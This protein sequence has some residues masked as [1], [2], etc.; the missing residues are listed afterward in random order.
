MF[1]E[2]NSENLGNCQS[3]LTIQLP[4]QINGDKA[5]LI[6]HLIKFKSNTT[7]DKENHPGN[8]NQDKLNGFHLENANYEELLMCST[9][10]DSC[11]V[12]S[13]KNR[14]KW[15]FIQS[16]DELEKLLDCLNIRGIRES[17][18]K[19]TLQESKEVLLNIISKTPG[20][21]L[22]PKIEKNHN[23]ATT[24]K[25]SSNEETNFGYSVDSEPTKVE[26]D[27]LLNLILKL[28]VKIHAG[29]LGTLKVIN[30]DEWRQILTKEDYKTFENIY[31]I[32]TNDVNG[33]HN[34]SRSST[35]DIKQKDP[36]EYFHHFVNKDKN[37]N[38]LDKSERRAIKC[39]ALALVQV[40]QGLDVR[41]LR[42]PLGSKKKL[43][44]KKKVPSDLL[45]KWQ[46]SLIQSSSYS[47]IFLHY[48]TFDN[49]VIW[50]KSVL[51]TK[52]RICRI[53]KDAEKMILCCKCNFGHHIYCLKPPLKV[54]Y[55][56][57]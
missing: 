9:K 27:V 14:N 38:Q 36:G 12:H 29:N 51:C 22:N 20:H 45:E 15:Y 57:N 40:S 17:E 4:Y 11:N 47:Q 35:P 8:E 39:L 56:R 49:C 46:Q 33:M 41:Y 2:C 54:S 24:T 7:S 28:E 34:G 50:A 55:K 3:E 31:K 13:L 52:C 1:I 10:P 30:R 23:Y 48:A 18:L 26:R 25:E 19:Q 37:V 5:K 44:A 21:I 42:Q 6:K 53:Q 32:E 43:K 16:Q